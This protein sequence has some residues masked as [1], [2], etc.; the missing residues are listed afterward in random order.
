MTL[1]DT[2]NPLM[3]PAGM[4]GR[5]GSIFVTATSAATEWNARRITRRAL[6]ELSDHELSDI[7]LTRADIDRASRLGR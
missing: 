7:G 3:G 5:I 4:A 6:S 1:L 2:H